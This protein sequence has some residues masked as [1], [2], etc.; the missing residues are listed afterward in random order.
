MWR[1]AYWA[2]EG[3][4]RHTIAVESGRECHAKGAGNFTA[5]PVVG[6]HT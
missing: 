6:G 2:Q 1:C 4:A 3:S 5:R